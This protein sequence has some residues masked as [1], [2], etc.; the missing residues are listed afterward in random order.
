VLREP[1]LSWAGKLGERLRN[2]DLLQPDHFN[3]TMAHDRLAHGGAHVSYPVGFF[4]EHRDQIPIAEQFRHDQRDAQNFPRST[5]LVSR[6]TISAA[7]I[8]IQL[9]H[10]PIELSLRERMLGLR[11][12][13]GRADTSCAATTKT[14]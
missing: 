4:A 1:V 11:P 13:Y 2:R 7:A 6:L 8:P 12:R 5:T 14:S 9:A 3:D 10:A